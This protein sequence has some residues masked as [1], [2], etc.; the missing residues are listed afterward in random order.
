MLYFQVVVV[1]LPPAY[2]RYQQN[3]G[4]VPEHS[5]ALRSKYWYGSAQKYWR[6][7]LAQ[8]RALAVKGR[9]PL[10]LHADGEDQVLGERTADELDRDGKSVHEATGER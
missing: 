4:E 7:R 6:V 8:F 10:V 3:G 9:H 1:L 5:T 2:P